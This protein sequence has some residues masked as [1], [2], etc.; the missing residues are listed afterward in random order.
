LELLA[1]LHGEKVSDAPT[2]LIANIGARRKLTSQLTVMGAVGRAVRGSPDER[3]RLLLY[4]GLQFNLPGRYAFEKAERRSARRQ[5]PSWWPGD[6][7]SRAAASG[8]P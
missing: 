8:H 3:P 1:E 5:P 4:V 7:P 2:E 6:M